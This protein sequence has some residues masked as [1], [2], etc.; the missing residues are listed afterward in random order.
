MTKNYLNINELDS[1]IKKAEKD[2]ASMKT[3]KMAAEVIAAQE[4]VIFDLMEQKEKFG[5][6]EL[7]KVKLTF[8]IVNDET[9]EVTEHDYRVAFVKNNR[10]IDHKKVDGFIP[11][12]AK[13][14]YEKAFPIIA[15]PA[16]KAARV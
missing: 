9:M 3:K 14:K 2:L 10:P 7:S 8:A 13:G 12:I 4:K 6:V 11:I 15:V 16:G 5:K 1:A